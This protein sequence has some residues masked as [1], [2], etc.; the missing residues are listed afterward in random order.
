MG[1]RRVGLWQRGVL[2]GGFTLVETLIA[3][4]LS[5]FV[6]VL[7]SH[8]FLVQN[9]FYATQTL[10]TAAQDNVR[11]ATELMAREVRT[12]MEAGILVAGPRTLTLRSPVAMAIVCS[13]QGAPNLDVYNE[14]G[15][16][17][18]DTDEIAGLAHRHPA[19]GVW[20]VV[21]ETWPNLD[22]STSNAAG[23]CADEGAD[24]VGVS[25]AFHRLSVP[26]SFF[27]T[28]PREGDVLMFFR[29]T[30]F[31]IQGSA[32]EPGSLAVFRAAYGD[33]LVELAT[34]VDTTAQFRYR[35]A[36]GTFSDTLSASAL[37]SIDAVQ[38]VADAR[39]RAP[40]GGV[41]DITFGWTVTVPLRTVR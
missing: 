4:V 40:T 11:A 25:A 6:I 22:G 27:S 12:A 17:G 30:T 2:P 1:G 34:G 19:T 35:T 20:E 7:V 31:K 26:G 5:S 23:N 10:R 39:K 13:R 32:L 3:L 15:E 18:L 28:N 14:G 8:S 21:N 16:A 41:D 9:R 29:E 36:G 38:I 37:A 33:S 24:T